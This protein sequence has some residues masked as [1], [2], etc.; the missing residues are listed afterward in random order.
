MFSMRYNLQSSRASAILAP[1]GTWSGGKPEA[2]S[3]RP[4]KL[5]KEIK[6][7]ISQ[8]AFS[9]QPAFASNLISSFPTRLGV[10]V[11]LLAYA[12]N[13][14]VSG[15]SSYVGQVVANSWLRCS[16]PVR[17][18]TAARWSPSQGAPPTFPFTTVA[19]ISRWSRLR[20]DAPRR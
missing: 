6:A 17:R 7:V 9:V 5:K 14:R 18:R 15:S 13:A 4:L 12:S 1:S 3:N 8:I 10:S 19:T 20:G 2:A 11:S 16:S